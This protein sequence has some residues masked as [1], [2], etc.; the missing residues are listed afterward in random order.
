M[1][2]FTGKTLLFA[3]FAVACTIVANA[4]KTATVSKDVTG[5]FR[6]IAAA[7]ASIPDNDEAW[8]VDIYPGLYVEHLVINRTGPLTLR[9]HTNCTE[10]KCQPTYKDN[11]VTIAWNDSA[12][13]GTTNEQT[14]AVWIRTNNFKAYNI[15]FNQTWGDGWYGQGP[16]AI[17]VTVDA[18]KVGFYHSGFYGWQDTLYVGD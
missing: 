5:H 6:T 16:Q 18:D 7:L 1:V 13:N 12:T 10:S 17:A 9:G 15:N 4:V 2:E 11:A 3:F 14:S 8:E